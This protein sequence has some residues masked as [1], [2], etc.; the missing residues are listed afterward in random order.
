MSL[1]LP[2]PNCLGCAIRAAVLRPTSSNSRSRP[3]PYPQITYLPP[4]SNRL[5]HLKVRKAPISRKREKTRA[6]LG[7]I[8]TS[9]DVPPLEFWKSVNQPPISSDLTP[10]E[11]HRAAKLYVDQAIKNRNRPGW[12]DTLTIPAHTLHT[13]AT[14]AALRVPGNFTHVV[15][16]ILFA[17]SKR[18][19][20][21][22]VLS[23]ARLGLRQR[24]LFDEMGKLENMTRQIE[25]DETAGKK[26]PSS[27]SS[28][29]VAAYAADICTLRALF[30]AA[31]NTT[32]GDANALR[33]FRRA[34]EIGNNNQT[35]TSTDV[36][37]ESKF[38]PDPDWQWKQSFAL[39]VGAIRARRGELDK[40]EAAYK[41]AA[42]ELDTAEGYRELAR[43]L[44]RKIQMGKATEDETMGQYSTYLLKAA[45]SGD[46]EAARML[47][48]REWRRAEEGGLS[49]WEDKKSRVLADEWRA[50]GTPP[51]H[52]QPTSIQEK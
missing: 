47:A 33:W 1:F 44:E 2:R 26:P 29:S 32:Q 45:I 13:I 4:R 12:Q 15:P 16:D 36:D 52:S 21:P 20:L 37:E 6:P 11:C 35:R 39:G 10:E 43:L 18:D 8:L 48:T 22:S 19:Y 23:R 49:K 50:V 46:Q 41:I 34:Y 5:I 38:D 28:S 30:Y 14:V 27:S 17:L 51:S 25:Q 40:A 7:E 42:L 3:I 9:A 31:E 24:W